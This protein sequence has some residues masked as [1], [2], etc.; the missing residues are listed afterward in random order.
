M[1]EVVTTI[2]H[3]DTQRELLEVDAFCSPQRVCR[4]KRNH[5]PKQIGPPTDVIR[6][7]VLT[8]VV[9]PEIPVHAARTEERSQRLQALQTAQTL[10][11][12][13]LVGQLI[14]G[15]VASTVRAIWLSHDT[16]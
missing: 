2:N 7:H 12:Y 11:N 13:E 1:S 15:F 16:D 8:V 10:S 6:A 5:N 14:A 4:E 3:L 9:V